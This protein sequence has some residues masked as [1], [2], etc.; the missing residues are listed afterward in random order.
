MSRTYTTIM[1]ITI[2]TFVVMLTGCE[3]QSAGRLTAEPA[4]ERQERLY[5]VE[6]EELKKQIADIEKQFE[7]DLAI[8]QGELDKCNE[9]MNVLQKELQE[10]MAKAFEESMT[11]ILVEQV[12][13]LTEENMQL[14]AQIEELNKNLKEEEEDDDEK[15][16]KEEE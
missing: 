16:E 14:K 9:N 15:E 11:D 12:Q 6:N 13:T 4:S 3:P 2:C 5:A 10:D 7:K 8:R 1:F